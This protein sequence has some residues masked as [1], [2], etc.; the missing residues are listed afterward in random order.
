MADIEMISIFFTQNIGHIDIDITQLYSPFEMAAQLYDTH[1]D[2][3][4]FSAVWP[5]H[6]FHYRQQSSQ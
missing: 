1:I 6:I 4:Y 5:A 2:I 3:L